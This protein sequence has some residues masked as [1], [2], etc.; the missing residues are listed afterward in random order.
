[1]VAGIAGALGA[2][3]LVFRGAVFDPAMPAFLFV[4]V[5]VLCAA[6]LAAVRISWHG[7]ALV[8]IVVFGLGRYGLTQS[9]GWL[10][11]LSG[12]LLGG[13]IYL[14][15]LVFDLLG[16]RGLVMGKFLIMGPMLGGLFVALTPMVEF[17]TLTSNGASRMLMLQALIGVLIGDGVGLGVELVE[18]PSARAARRAS[19]D[20]PDGV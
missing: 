4:T 15:V 8:F 14:V 5:G 20:P 18:L 10:F 12:F 2:G 7:L 17:H 16:R 19:L 3:A 13:G 9:G 6:V 1:M 11:G